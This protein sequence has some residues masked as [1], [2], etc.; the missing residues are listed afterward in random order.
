M[1]SSGLSG[2]W[3]SVK[4][5]RQPGDSKGFRIVRGRSWGESLFSHDGHT[6]FMVDSSYGSLRLQIHD[7]MPL[8]KLSLNGTWNSYIT[9]RAYGSAKFRCLHRNKT[10]LLAET[11]LP[12]GVKLRQHLRLLTCELC[13]L[14][15]RNMKTG[16]EETQLFRRMAV[17]RFPSKQPLH[18]RN[19]TLQTFVKVGRTAVERPKEVQLVKEA[20][21]C[22]PFR[23]KAKPL[24]IEIECQKQLIP[25]KEKTASDLAFPQERRYNELTLL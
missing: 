16:E 10:E 5:V 3:T 19:K 7:H 13:I 23:R 21:W 15:V 25:V 9:P 24:M 17:Q 12:D 1:N 6:R 4:V 2:A 20:T 11:L 18:D 8:H 22:L 14:H